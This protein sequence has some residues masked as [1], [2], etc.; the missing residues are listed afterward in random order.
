M[1]WKLT[2]DV[3]KPWNKYPSDSIHDPKIFQEVKKEIVS[4][5]KNYRDAIK[6]QLGP[7]YL[8]SY[9]EI[10]KELS[11]SKSLNTFNHYWN[12]FYDFADNVR[13]WVKTSKF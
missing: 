11:K 5:L 8:P 10:I 1:N 6:T 7:D 9:D 2:I 13:I 4:I 3:S 12:Q